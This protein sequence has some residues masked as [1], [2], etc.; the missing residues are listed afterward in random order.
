MPPGPR[1]RIRLPSQPVSTE[2]HQRLGRYRNHWGKLDER[3][4]CR[5]VREDIT[6]ALSASDAPRAMVREI[7]WAFRSA[8]TARDEFRG[9]RALDAARTFLASTGEIARLY[10]APPARYTWRGRVIR[11]PGPPE[12][13]TLDESDPNGRRVRLEPAPLV[14]FADEELDAER[15]ATRVAL[16]AIADAQVLLDLGH[17]KQLGRPPKFDSKSGQASLKRFLRSARARKH[18]TDDRRRGWVNDPL[19]RERVAIQTALAELIA[20][21]P[22]LRKHPYSLFVAYRSRR[23]VVPTTYRTV[24]RILTD[25]NEN[26]LVQPQGLVTRPSSASKSAPATV[27]SSGRAPTTPD[28]GRPRGRAR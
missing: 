26:G 27:R 11:N 12:T 9:F 2:E 17:P 21:T 10:H 8:A 4:V 1:I 6:A 25:M 15:R 20:A 3:R 23:S 14:A 22:S 28:S 5:L 18:R 7:Q 24:F 16:Q 19:S 13:Y